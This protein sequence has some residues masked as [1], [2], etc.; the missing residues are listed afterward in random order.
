MILPGGMGYPASGIQQKHVEVWGGREPSTFD[1]KQ[2]KHHPVANGNKI[3]AYTN[4]VMLFD[5]QTESF[6]WTDSLPINNNCPN[7]EIHDDYIYVLAEETGTGC[8]F[9]KAYG[10]HPALVMRGKITI[11]DVAQTAATAQQPP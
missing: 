5:T 3:N 9:G 2:R 6:H 7:V 1:D 11:Q 8:A 4:G 10:Q